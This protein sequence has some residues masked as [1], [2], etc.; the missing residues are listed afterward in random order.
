MQKTATVSGI[1]FNVPEFKCAK[2]NCTELRFEY[3]SSNNSIKATCKKCGKFFKFVKHDPRP[4][5]VIRKEAIEKWNAKNKIPK[6]DDHQYIL[7]CPECNESVGKPL[8]RFSEIPDKFTC[9]MCNAKWDG[10]ENT[11]IQHTKKR[12]DYNVE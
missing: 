2:C 11:L 5:E 10:V 3:L 7:W 12:D 6:N 8:S 9:H 1:T 4:Q